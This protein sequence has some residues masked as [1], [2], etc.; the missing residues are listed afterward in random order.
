MLEPPESLKSFY[1]IINSMVKSLRL[2]NQQETI[3]ILFFIRQKI[4]IFYNILYILY[5]LCFFFTVNI[6]LCFS[7]IPQGYNN[8][9]LKKAYIVCLMGKERQH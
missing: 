8:N 2:A 3:N 7:F 6:L 4:Q 5:I 9:P 1:Y